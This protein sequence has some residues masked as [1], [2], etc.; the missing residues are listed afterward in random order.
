MRIA[1]TLTHSLVNGEG[2]RYVIFTQGC[3]H[4]CPGCHNPETHDPNGG[5]EESLD[6]LKRELHTQKQKL[7][8]GVTFSGGDP[9]MQPEEC[10]ELAAYAHSIGLDVWA[11]TGWKYEAL[12]GDAGKRRFLEQVDV[13]V[14]GPFIEELKSDACKFRGSTNQRII[15]VK[16]SLANGEVTLWQDV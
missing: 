5:R 12:L 1:G 10:A 14:D 3:P 9:F 6:S 13:L 4:H 2:L 7:T 8:D 16:E 15:D 11:Y